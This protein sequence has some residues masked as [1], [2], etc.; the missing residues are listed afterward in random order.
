[1]PIPEPVA[2]QQPVAA[3]PSLQQD[4]LAAPKIEPGQPMQVVKP[5]APAHDDD[6]DRPL[7]IK[8]DGYV[9]VQFPYLSIRSTAIVSMG[10]GVKWKLSPEHTRSY[11]P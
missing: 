7:H 6:Y 11:G 8:E 3:V 1:M 9:S 4:T 10:G 2:E 5:S